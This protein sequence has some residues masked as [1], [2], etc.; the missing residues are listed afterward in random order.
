MKQKAKGA[1]RKQRDY[2]EELTIKF[3]LRIEEAISNAEK[4]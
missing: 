1:E 4:A 2:Q 3:M